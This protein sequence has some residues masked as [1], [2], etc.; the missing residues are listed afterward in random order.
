MIQIYPTLLTRGELDLEEYYEEEDAF[1]SDE[2]SHIADEI[3]N[4]ENLAEEECSKQYARII[5]P[6]GASV[7]S[8][9]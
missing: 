6:R 4:E 7:I 8:S 3:F 9:F 5:Y 2:I 1:T